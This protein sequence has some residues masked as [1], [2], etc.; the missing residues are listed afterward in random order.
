M[1]ITKK[2][3]HEENVN[4]LA[5]LFKVLG[6][7]ARISV[8][9]ILRERGSASVG[10]LVDAIGLAQSTV[11]EHIIELKRIPLIRGTQIGTSMQYELHEAMWEAVGEVFEAFYQD[12]S[13]Q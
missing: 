4:L 6:H 9:Q 2:E 13:L 12:F 11:S 7:P 1:G 8:L 3:L 10:E 5:T